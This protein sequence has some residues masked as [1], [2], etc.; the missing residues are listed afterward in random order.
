MTLENFDVYMHP[1]IEE[2]QELWLGVVA[3]DV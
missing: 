2:L 3:Y 1:L